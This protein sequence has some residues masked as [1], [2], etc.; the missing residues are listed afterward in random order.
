MC[1]HGTV[2]IYP[3]VVTVVQ[4]KVANHGSNDTHETAGGKAKPRKEACANF[5]LTVDF[6][7]D[8]W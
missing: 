3:S 7:F 5:H 8:Y 2:R 4:L 6:K 1:I